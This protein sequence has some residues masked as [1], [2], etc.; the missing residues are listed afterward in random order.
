MPFGCLVNKF[1][2]DMDASDI[3]TGI[4]AQRF[5]MISWDIDDASPVA[6]LVQYFLD[7]RIVAFMPKPGP[8][9]PPPVDGAI[10]L[11]LSLV[12]GRS[13]YPHEP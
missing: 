7:H 8:F 4:V 6:D 5:I 3:K 11:M 10:V 12:P 9:D 13:H 2:A 1:I